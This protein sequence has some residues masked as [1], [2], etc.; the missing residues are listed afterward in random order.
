MI[1]RICL[2]LMISLLISTGFV[3]G[4]EVREPAVAGSFYPASAD[5]LRKMIEGFLKK[6]KIKRIE[7]DPV[8]LI[9]PH[10]GYIFSGGVAA[11]AFKAIEGFD[12]VQGSRF[13]VR[14]SGFDV[15]IIGPS[16]HASFPGAS[17]YDGKA[18]RTPLGEVPIDRDVVRKLLEIDNTIRFYP[19]AHAREHSIEVVLPFLQMTLKG[20]KIVPILMYDFSPDNCKR[21]SD[22]LI[23]A[24]KGRK[25]LLVA[26][27]DMSHY[28]SYEDARKVDGETIK[29]VKSLNP[30]AVRQNELRWMKAGVKELYCTLCGLGPVVT[31]MET[32]KRMGADSVKVLK[33]ANSGDVPYGGKSRVVGYMAAVIYRQPPLHS[34]IKA[35]KEVAGDA[36]I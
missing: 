18:Y 1:R 31:V 17:V 36:D 25:A 5:Q 13:G 27:S 34:R 2:I 12:M 8:A 28:P 26:S 11:Y 21:L 20:F 19:S 33:Y 22:A 30:E 23:K 35:K 4:A 6:A 10:A 3:R 16:H 7:G 32:A 24:L 14:G 15:V 29:A 9:L